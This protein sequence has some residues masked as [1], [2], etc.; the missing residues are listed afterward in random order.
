[1]NKYNGLD[2]GKGNKKMWLGI[3]LIIIGLMLWTI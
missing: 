3:I 1:M 2:D